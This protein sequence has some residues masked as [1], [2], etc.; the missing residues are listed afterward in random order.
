MFADWTSLSCFI[1]AS[2]PDYFQYKKRLDFAVIPKAA[3]HTEQTGHTG[4]KH[5]DAPNND[6]RNFTKYNLPGVLFKVVMVFLM[7][8]SEACRPSKPFDT[9]STIRIPDCNLRS[10]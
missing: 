10:A 4:R 9:G 8:M 7:R 2:Q 6:R 5:A 3:S 1:A